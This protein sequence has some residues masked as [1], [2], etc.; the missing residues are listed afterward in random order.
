MKRVILSGRLS[1]I[2]RFT[3]SRF[4][5]QYCEL[6]MFTGAFTAMVTPFRNGKV[7]EARLREQVEFQI[8]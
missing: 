5:F 7:D 3:F 6:T 4:T 1:K 2:T 8:A